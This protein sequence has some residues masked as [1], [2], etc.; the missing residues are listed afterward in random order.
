[1][2]RLSKKKKELFVSIM[3]KSIEMFKDRVIVIDDMYEHVNFICD[4]FQL[5]WEAGLI[6]FDDWQDISDWFVKQKPTH[7]KHKQFY[8]SYLYDRT[9]WVLG[10]WTSTDDEC[11]KERIR[12]LEHLIKTLE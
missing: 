11:R 2:K 5:Q 4:S 6:S 12:F 3:S 10:W 1:M 7:K 9:S 8:D